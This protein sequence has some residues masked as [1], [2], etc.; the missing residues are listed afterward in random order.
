MFLCVCYVSLL[1]SKYPEF[2]VG[3]INNSLNNPVY[4]SYW[5]LGT[6]QIPLAPF[7][8]V[9]EPKTRTSL[10]LKNMEVQQ[11]GLHEG[12]DHP[13][14]YSWVYE[15]LLAQHFGFTA[16]YS[17][18]LVYSQWPL[19]TCCIL[20]ALFQTTGR[21]SWQKAGEHSGAFRSQRA[22]YFYQ[23]LVETKTG[24]KEEYISDFWSPVG[25]KDDSQR[26]QCCLMEVGRYCM[27]ALSTDR[28]DKCQCIV[29]S[30]LFL[31]HWRAQNIS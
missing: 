10:T 3:T 19:K 28:A 24:A 20:S 13:E 9:G 15:P 1:I 29:Y 27:F 30:S 14:S 5:N 31:L 25:Q 11:G 12:L 17:T 16:C 23:E 2:E 4:W 18:V 21:Q 8:R 6:S 22:K 26:T 7:S